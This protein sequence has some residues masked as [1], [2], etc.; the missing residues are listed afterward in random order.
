M[1]WQGIGGAVDA[2]LARLGQANRGV[3][4]ARKIHYDKDVSDETLRQHVG[5]EWGWRWAL[6]SA[7]YGHVGPDGKPII[8]LG[9]REGQTISGREQFTASEVAVNQG[10]HLAVREHRMLTRATSHYISANVIDE[11]NI[12]ASVAEPEPLFETDL[13]TRDGF[14]VLEK[15]LVMPDL[16]GTTG[17]V[18]PTI[19]T[20]IRAIGW[21]REDAIYSN[22]DDQFHPGVSI[23]VYTTAED[24][25]NG[26][27]RTSKEAGIDAYDPEMVADNG[28][29]PVEVVPWCF[30]VNWTARDEAEYVP[31]TVPIPIAMER[32]W[33]MAFMRLC[34][35]DI[36][37][38]KVHRPDRPTRRRWERL[39]K[40]K[41]LDYSVLR[42]RREVDPNYKP[43]YTGTALNYRR[44]TR[45]YP[46]RV[47]LK[48]KGPARLPDGRMDPHTHR[49]IWIE[50]YWSGPEDGPLG[51]THKATAVVR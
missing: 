34:W 42:L 46:M 40:G 32:R 18:H 51:P 50:P 3:A 30:G 20:Y 5:N 33:F 37:V 11:I 49:L 31:G 15:P 12:F 21:S 13:F 39:A 25:E 19:T 16:D 44:H 14:A 7:S 47:H 8:E 24:Y 26:F 43:R 10:A 35:Q 48:S 17:R 9:I 36:V 22:V 41:M 6:F 29:V 4:I 28:V 1:N 45:G 38:R 27:Y 23:F 2:H